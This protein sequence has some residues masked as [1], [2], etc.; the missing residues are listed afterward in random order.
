[1]G[2]SFKSHVKTNFAYNKETRM[3]LSIISF[4]M[5]GSC[6]FCTLCRV[7]SNFTAGLISR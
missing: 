1:M 4:V 5:E 3:R 6:R 7:F 2:S